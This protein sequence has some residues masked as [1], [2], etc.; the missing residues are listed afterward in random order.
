MDY[1]K[2]IADLLPGYNC[3]ACNYRRCDL[4]AEMI[5]KVKTEEKCPFLLKEEFKENK[6]KIKELVSNI[7]INLLKTERRFKGLDDY[8]ADFLLDPLPGEPSGRMTLLIMGK[9]SL[10]VGDLVKFRPLGCPITHFA[11]I[12]DENYGVYVVHIVGPCHRIRDD[13]F[14]Y[15]D[16]GIAIPV[17]IE[18]MVVGKL[19]EVGQ[20]VKFIPAHCMRQKVHSGVV[21]EAE[22]KRVYIECVDF[23]I[24]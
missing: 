12:I 1:I 14:E 13:K 15:K 21:V 19:P 17:A 18:G 2:K 5:L 8:E 7:D 16:V 23:K 10:K 3:N 24:W 4:F 22:G 11:K 9:I 20:T 6:K